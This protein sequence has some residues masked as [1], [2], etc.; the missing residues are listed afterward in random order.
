MENLK[1]L[2]ID[3]SKESIDI[4][5]VRFKDF[6]Y[7]IIY[8]QEGNKAFEVALEKHP[9][10][11]LCDI[12][13]PDISGIE[14]AKLLKND[15]IT[16]DIPIIFLTAQNSKSDI[17]E[18]I[19]VGAIDYITKPFIFQ[20]LQL[21]IQNHFDIISAKKIKSD[22]EKE[23]LLKAFIIKVNHELNQ[24]ISKTYYSLYQLKKQSESSELLK[25][26]KSIEEIVEFIRQLSGLVGAKFDYESY[27]NDELMIKLGKKE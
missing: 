16:K 25:L 27:G 14:V 6:P 12:I 18:G 7:E 3:D 21:K 10:L 26:E 5:K 1:I 23:Q 9:D 13:M 17:I 24:T 19:K 4:F 15:S 22:R 8:C 20:E 11:I 2:L